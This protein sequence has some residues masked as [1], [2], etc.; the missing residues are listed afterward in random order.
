[1]FV[2]VYII[3]RNWKRRHA[4]LLF[5]RGKSGNIRVHFA[6]MSGIKSSKH[7]G[8]GMVA[9]ETGVNSPSMAQSHLF[10]ASVHG[11]GAGAEC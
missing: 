1:M 3:G 10:R 6:F 8:K 7:S 4:C 5:F 11:P 9:D 2:N